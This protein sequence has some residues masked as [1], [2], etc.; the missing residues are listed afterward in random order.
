MLYLEIPINGGDQAEPAARRPIVS[1]HSHDTGVVPQAATHDLRKRQPTVSCDDS[2]AAC[3]FQIAL[4]DEGRRG[5]EYELIDLSNASMDD[6]QKASVEFEI[7]PS[8]QL[9]KPTPSVGVDL[10]A[11]IRKPARRQLL[12]GTAGREPATAVVSAER[13]LFIAIAHDDSYAGCTDEID[14]GRRIAAIGGQVASAD[15]LLSCDAEPFGLRKHCSRRR[16]IAIR[17]AE[18]ENGP[19]NT[20]ERSCVQP[21]TPGWKGFTL[22]KL[23]P[24]L[25]VKSL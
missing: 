6:R 4:L 8:R 12:T 1:G 2:I 21:F 25:K 11:G 23:L 14:R 5:R 19:I 3:Q 10:G 7:N 24:A 15:R 22:P 16:E 13:Q 20:N 17:P 18:N 9:R